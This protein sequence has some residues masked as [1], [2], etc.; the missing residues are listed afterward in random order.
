MQCLI[1]NE[2]NVL[3]KWSLFYPTQITFFTETK[4]VSCVRWRFGFGGVVQIGCVTTLSRWSWEGQQQQQQ[5]QVPVVEMVGPSHHQTPSAI[6]PGCPVQL[7]ADCNVTWHDDAVR[8]STPVTPTSR[9]GRPPPYPTPPTARK[10][11]P[12]RRLDVDETAACLESSPLNN[13]CQ[14]L[15][16]SV[17]VRATRSELLVNDVNN[18]TSTYWTRRK[19]LPTR[20]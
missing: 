16:G 5:K 6:Y 15:N 12:P 9:L 11:V 1:E 3:Q 13:C 17:D 4:Y 8:S 7:S 2:N 19:S 18:R 14:R 10:H 20:K